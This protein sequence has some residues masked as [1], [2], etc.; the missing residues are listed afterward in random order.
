[1]PLRINRGRA[2]YL[3]PY[4]PEL[5]LDLGGGSKTKRDKYF[6]KRFVVV[7]LSVCLVN[8][9]RNVR[10]DDGGLPIQRGS[11]LISPLSI[12][13]NDPSMNNVPAQIHH[14]SMDL[15][16]SISESFEHTRFSPSL[17]TTYTPT[18]A[19]VCV[20]EGTRMILKNEYRYKWFWLFQSSSTGEQQ[21]RFQSLSS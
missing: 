12:C 6:L 5:E 21:L 17:V 20:S 11:L 2:T 4:V 7:A 9:R 1:M 3:R 18:S 10:L 16:I 15:T 13:T 8:N 14:A 19:C